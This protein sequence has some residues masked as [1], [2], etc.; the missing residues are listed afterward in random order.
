VKN[1]FYTATIKLTPKEGYT[2]TGVA[3]D[4]FTVAGATKV[5]NPAGSGVITAVFP[6]TTQEIVDI[7][8]MEGVKIPT[9]GETPA[10][11]ITARTQY[12]GT[13]TWEPNNKTFDG[14]TSYTAT[15][16]L[17]PKTNFT[18]TGVPVDFFSVPG[19]I[20][21]TNAENSGVI[22]A[23]FP[24]TTLTP[25]NISAI[26]L[27][28]PVSGN[29][30]VTEIETNQYTGTVS[31]KPNTAT[32]EKGITYTATVTLTPKEDYTVLGVV[33]NFFTATG[34][35]NVTYTSGSSEVAAVY[36]AT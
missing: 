27:P 33:K 21:V 8:V 22:K 10:A 20:S 2:L 36:P 6:A 17:T 30:P 24:K 23:T 26:P 13:V 25:I 32:F 29:T 3:K 19:A 16:T 11:K 5:S 18:F 31:W 12:T 28:R 35:S 9:R 1:K 4:F 34:A 14:N 15:I 7:A